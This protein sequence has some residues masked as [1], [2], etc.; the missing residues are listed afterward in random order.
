MTMRQAGQPTLAEM[1]QKIP[2][3]VSPAQIKNVNAVIQIRSTGANAGEWVV[4]IKNG[5]ATVAAG[6]DPAATL[7]AEAASEVWDSLIS[8]QLD[9]TWAYMSGKLRITGDLDLAM[10]LQ[11]V[12]GLG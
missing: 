7:T 8:R 11:S 2:Q 3:N 5:A 1:L 6:S 9:P 10:R 12:L 4:T